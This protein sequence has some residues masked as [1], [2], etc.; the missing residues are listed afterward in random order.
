MMPAPLTSSLLY[1]RRAAVGGLIISLVSATT[2]EPPAPPP[3]V[4]ASTRP[5]RRR[6][7]GIMNGRNTRGS[8]HATGQI[9]AFACMGEVKVELR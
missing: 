9:T 7:V 2:A 3:A 5:A 4:P 8:W 6:L 1:L